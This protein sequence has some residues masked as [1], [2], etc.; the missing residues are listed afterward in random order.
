MVIYVLVPSIHSFFY[1]TTDLL[2]SDVSSTQMTS[3]PTV[4][5]LQ[6]SHRVHCEEE[7]GAH[8]QLSRFTYK[9][10]FFFLQIFKVVYFAKKIRTFQKI[11]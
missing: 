4:F 10:D 11:P 3:N 7:T 9:F 2:K 1:L 6:A 8:Y 5:S